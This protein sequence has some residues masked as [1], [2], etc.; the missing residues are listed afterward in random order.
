MNDHM[1]RPAQKPRRRP[2]PGTGPVARDEVSQARL[3]AGC[4]RRGGFPPPGLVLAGWLARPGLRRLLG[5]GP[6]RAGR[7]ARAGVARGAG[8]VA[9]QPGLGF[10]GLL[11]QLRAKAGLTQEELAEAAGL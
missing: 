7:C 10:A 6:A 4:Q 11:R 8:A 9:E 2:P 1:N 5:V 3:R